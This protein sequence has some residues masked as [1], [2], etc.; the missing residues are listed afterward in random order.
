MVVP[1]ASV[2]RRGK[3]VVYLLDVGLHYAGREAERKRK[4]R[5]GGVET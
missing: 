1:I 2:E 4:G 5:G 3:F